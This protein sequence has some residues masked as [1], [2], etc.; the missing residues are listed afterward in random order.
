MVEVYDTNVHEGTPWIAMELLEGATLGELLE[1][2]LHDPDGAIE[3]GGDG[4]PE[5][6]YGH[7]KGCMICVAQ[8]PPH[9]IEAV[10]EHQAQAEEAKG[11]ST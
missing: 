2:T 5:I 4:T 10:P 9:A 3:V 8:C 1:H 11:D 7:C 6:D